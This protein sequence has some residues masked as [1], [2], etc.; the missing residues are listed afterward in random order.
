M[1]LNLI[2]NHW[3]LDFCFF[4]LR[5][6]SSKCKYFRETLLFFNNKVFSTY[7]SLVCQFINDLENKLSSSFFWRIRD[8][9]FLE[10]KFLG[11]EMLLYHDRSKYRYEDRELQAWIFSYECSWHR[12]KL[13]WLQLLKHLVLPLWELSE[14]VL[15]R[16][17]NEL[18]LRMQRL[19]LSSFIS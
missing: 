6:F 19:I 17:M 18:L 4:I 1:L 10:M 7:D 5:A 16:W 3:R 14:H 12:V 13:Y 15:D 9:D 11:A 2:L 8:F